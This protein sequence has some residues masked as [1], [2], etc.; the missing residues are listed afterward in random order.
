MSRMNEDWKAF[1]ASDAVSG[2]SVEAPSPELK[3]AIDGALASDLEPSFPLVLGKLGFIH[4]ATSIL[5]LSVCPQFGFRLFG[6]GMGL[7]HVLMR[8]GEWGCAVACGFLFVGASVLL[9]A[10]IMRR[11]EWRSIRSN[12]LLALTAL[13]LPS[14]GFFK[15]MDGEFFLEFSIGWLIGALLVSR[16]LLEGA[17]RLKDVFH[18]KRLDERFAGT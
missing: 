12:G 14:L 17:W 9:G 15:V 13:T 11:S 1:L 6:E 3:T 5:T 7:M 18:Q 16:L 2:K 4:V 10:L 8:L